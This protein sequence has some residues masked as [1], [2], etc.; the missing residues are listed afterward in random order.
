MNILQT[1]NY[2]IT[3]C[4][5]VSY[6]NLFIDAGIDIVASSHVIIAEK[7][8]SYT[9]KRQQCSSCCVVPVRE[10]RNVLPTK[11]QN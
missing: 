8:G 11:V 6:S 1:D 2:Q 10:Q 9:T 5:Q 3:F 7:Y 4:M